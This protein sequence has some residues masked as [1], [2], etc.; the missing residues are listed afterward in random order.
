MIAV[1]LKGGLGNQMF[2]YAAARAQALRLGTGFFL[3]RSFLDMDSG[4]RWTKREYELDIF[5]GIAP[6]PADLSL[7]ILKF[8]YGHRYEARLSALPAS[9]FPFSV[10][11]EKG[12]HYDSSI[13][14]CGRNTYLDG[15]FQCEKYFLPFEKEIRQDFQFASPPEGKNAAVIREIEEQPLAISVHVRR[16]DY[17][18]L[19]AANDFHGT[20]ETVYYEEGARRIC[21]KVAG[22]PKFYLFSDDP[23]WVREHLRLPGEMMVIDW[24]QGKQSFEDMRLMSHCHHHIIANSSFSWWGAWLNPSPDKVVI[25]PAIWFRG[26]EDQPG[27]ILPESWMK[28]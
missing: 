3:D 25:A 20:M 13:H 10:F 5:S 15:Y 2:Q 7:R 23:Q 18:S 21:S 14:F 4:G 6:S 24:N 9:L 17:V 26:Q 22:S 11:R 12:H 19:A 28:I 8:V 16:G 27:D 1:Q